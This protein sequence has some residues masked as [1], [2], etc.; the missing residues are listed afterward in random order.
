MSSVNH[1]VG[2]IAEFNRDRENDYVSEKCNVFGMDEE[3][4]QAGSRP[5]VGA[6]NGPRMSRVIVVALLVFLTF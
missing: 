5:S 3:E 4:F 2:I 6:T 1:V